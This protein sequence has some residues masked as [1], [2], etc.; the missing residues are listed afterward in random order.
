MYPEKELL[1]WLGAN[2]LQNE[3]PGWLRNVVVIRL[4]KRVIK[5]SVR[6]SCK[7]QSSRDSLSVWLDFTDGVMVEEDIEAMVVIMSQHVR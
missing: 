5:A 3:R 2:N 7:L 4:A 6:D 1:G